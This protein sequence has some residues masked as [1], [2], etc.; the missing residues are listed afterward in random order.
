M[1]ICGPTLHAHVPPGGRLLDS[2]TMVLPGLKNK[3]LGNTMTKSYE[4]Q[5]REIICNGTNLVVGGVVL[6]LGH[7]APELEID[8]KP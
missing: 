3:L 5:R 1:K 7:V 6:G 4:K 8:L 2:T